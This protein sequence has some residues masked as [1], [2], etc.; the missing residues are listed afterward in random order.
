MLAVL[1]PLDRVALSTWHEAEQQSD[2][3]RKQQHTRHE[4]TEIEGG[5]LKLLEQS[6]N[7]LLAVTISVTAL[8]IGGLSGD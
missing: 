5:G 2:S 1:G 8:K 7:P 6:G 4:N 3:R